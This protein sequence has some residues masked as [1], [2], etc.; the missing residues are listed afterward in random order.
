MLDPSLLSA[1]NPQGPLVALSPSS[2]SNAGHRCDDSIL[3]VRLRVLSATIELQT[4]LD[5]CDEPVD[6]A[7]CVVD[8]LRD[9][10]P[11]K[12]ALLAWRRDEDTHSRIVA[13]TNSKSAGAGEPSRFAQAAAEEAMARACM[14]VW[15]PSDQQNR[16]A[17]LAIAQFAGEASVSQVTA[18]PLSDMSGRSRGAL[19]V[20]DVADQSYAQRLLDVIAAPLAGKLESLRRR[21]P[22][23]LERF[24]STVSETLDRR[25]RKTVIRCLGVISLLMLIPVRYKVSR[26]V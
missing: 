22:N 12:R 21:E 23:R 9:S 16:H 14:T 2:L 24:A 4:Q 20:A 11:C 18:V 5:T 25:R 19:L 7:Q 6:A 15:P 1:A 3:D 10:L 8:R 13:D 17:M 26:G